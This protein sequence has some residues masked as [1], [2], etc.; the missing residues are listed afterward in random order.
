MAETVSLST[1]DASNVA[2]FPEG[3]APSTVNNGARALEGML[4]RNIRDTQGYITAGG[5][6]N[7]LTIAL[8]ATTAA[9]ATG[10]R[11]TFKAAATNTAA[12]TVTVTPSG[13]AA[14][15]ARNIFRNGAALTGGEIISGCYYTLDWDGTQYQLTNPNPVALT[16]GRNL[17]INGEM[18]VAQL[19]ATITSP[20][21]GDIL[22]D[23]WKWRKV[24]TGEVTVTQ[25]TTVPNSTFVNSLKVDV[26]TA[27]T[28]IAATD[29]YYLVQRVEG[30]RSSRAGFGG[31][32]AQS[33][34]LSFWVR[35]DS[36]AL[37]FPAVFTGC[38][39]NAQTGTRS[40]PFTYSV[41]ASATWQ[42]ITITIAGDTT[43]TWLTTSGIGMELD[44]AFDVGSNFQ[45]T[46]SA[47]AAADAVGTSAQ[48][49]FM[50]NTANDFYVTGVQL[51][52]GSVA[53]P[54]EFRDYG[55]E[56]R[57][58][59][60]YYRRYSGV[61]D[62]GV[63]YYTST[64]LGRTF[65]PFDVEMRTAPTLAVS[66]AADFNLQYGATTNVA[67]TAVAFA[68][69]GAST[70]GATIAFTGTGTP[71]TAGQA[72]YVEVN[73]SKWLDLSAEL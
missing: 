47:W 40:Y 51:E 73:S 49:N 39:K 34:T 56:L 26:T 69:N 64:S 68:N 4:A 58:C 70:F 8:N 33:V 54:F 19:G 63:V 65:V 48:V 5:T 17:L 61:E 31:A 50:G 44:L 38:L 53:T 72:G 55:E 7:A 52:V 32:G 36:A 18:K 14:R 45:G 62:L 59:K 23:R 22:M 2:R 11:I 35:V 6:A 27:D 46:A 12:A 13:V 71:F 25:S 66:A 21:I 57:L 16:A 41:T 20:V 29:V 60:R 10:E 67:T 43:G 24:G 42:K 28:S 37:S 15:A 30:L 3:Q 1:T 9:E